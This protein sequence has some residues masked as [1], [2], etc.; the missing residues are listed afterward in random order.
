MKTK[1][2]LLA[3]LCWSGTIFAQIPSP[4]QPARLVND[5]ANIFTQSQVDILEQRLTA[6][7]DSTSNVICVVTV[8]DLGDYTAQDFAYEIGEK[9]GVKDKNYNNGV[10]ILVKPKI[11]NSYGDVA[12]AVGY[13]LEAVIPDITAK[14]IID[15]EMIPAFKEGNYYKGVVAAVDVICP[16]AA[17]EI[18]AERLY[19][20]KN[21]SILVLLSFIVISTALLIIFSGKNKNNH[22]DNGNGSNHWLDALLWS[23]VFSTGNH[24][25]DK[26]GSF[27]G[28][29]GFGGGGASGR[30]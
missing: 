23:S 12:I 6:F 7:N 9:W 25:N 29:G 20:N 18:S 1:W 27:G 22:N 21:G 2:L 3:I 17:G 28:G 11:E 15:N 13:D 30:W 5:F 10:V 16:L 4:P 19:Q 24:S 8:S 26:W 14:H